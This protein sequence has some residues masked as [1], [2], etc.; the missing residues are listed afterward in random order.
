MDDPERIFAAAARSKRCCGR[1]EG[2]MR[3]IGFTGHKGPAIHRHMFEVAQQHG[4]HFDTVQMPVNIMDAHF[5]SFQ[6]TI[7]PIAS[8]S[9]RRGARDEAFG[10]PFILD[11]HAA[12]TRSTCCTTR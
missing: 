7:F 1:A 2:K 5:D 4:F 12:P 10:D 8:A 6:K 11:S 3:F 9:G